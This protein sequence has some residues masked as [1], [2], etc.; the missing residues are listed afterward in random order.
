MPLYQY[1]CR[2]HKCGHTFEHFH[3]SLKNLDDVRCPKCDSARVRRD[4]SSVNWN[5][6]VKGPF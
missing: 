3:K 5:I 1:V 4:W 2:E 6:N